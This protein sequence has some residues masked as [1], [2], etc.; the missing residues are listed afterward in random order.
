MPNVNMSQ[1]HPTGLLSFLYDIFLSHPEHFATITIY[2]ESIQ[3]T[4]KKHS[5]LLILIFN[6]CRYASLSNDGTGFAYIL[7]WRY[8]FCNQ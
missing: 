3:E 2:M 4:L 1:M 8:K 7:K 6:Y 5:N